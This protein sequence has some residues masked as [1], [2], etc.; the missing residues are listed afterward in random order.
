ML[1]NFCSIFYLLTKKIRTH[2][3]ILNEIE[4]LNERMKKYAKE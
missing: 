4:V 3:L 2:K 1:Y